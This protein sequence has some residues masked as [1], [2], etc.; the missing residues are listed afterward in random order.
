MSKARGVVAAGHELTVA[1]A[2][3]ILEDGGNA[4]DA[5]LAGA[6]MTFAA[7]AVFASPGGGGFLMARQA[8]SDRATLFDFF[9]ETAM[10]GLE[11]GQDL[12]RIVVVHKP[13]LQHG[14]FVVTRQAIIGEPHGEILGAHIIGPEATEMIAE[15]GLA[16]TLEATYEEIEATIHAHPT[17]SE[18]VHEAAGQAFG[19]AIHI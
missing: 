4:F 13:I 2:A 6:F 16:M 9:V 19:H 11:Q 17:L 18:S 7:E 3:E 12:A 15:L 5:A 10:F 8:G 14:R 1:A